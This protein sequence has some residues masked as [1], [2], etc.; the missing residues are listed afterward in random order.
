MNID[1]GKIALAAGINGQLALNGG[2]AGM[3]IWSALAGLTGYL[4]AGI[5]NRLA[6]RRSG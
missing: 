2:L 1:T 6:N 5:Y 3:I 4:R